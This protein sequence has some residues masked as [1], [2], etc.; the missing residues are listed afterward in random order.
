MGIKLLNV[1]ISDTIHYRL[2]KIAPD[3][4]INWRNTGEPAYRAVERVVEAA[5]TKFLD[6]LETR[7]KARVSKHSGTK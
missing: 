5:L 3:P 6:D 7:A 2:Y 1:E 4:D